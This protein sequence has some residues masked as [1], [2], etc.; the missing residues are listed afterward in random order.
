MTFSDV[1]Q[2][3]EP[4]E[5]ETIW[6]RLVARKDLINATGDEMSLNMLKIQYQLCK[7]FGKKRSICS[8]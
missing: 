8:V 2:K 6:C 5:L 1:L 4:L 3:C 7:I